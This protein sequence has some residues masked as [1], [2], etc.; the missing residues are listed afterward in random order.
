MLGGKGGS[1]IMPVVVQFEDLIGNISLT[2]TQTGERQPNRAEL[3]QFLKDFQS[4][5]F[6]RVLVLLGEND[7]YS[8]LKRILPVVR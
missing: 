6:E 3:K 1:F 8:E 7:N 2:D 5:R 4:H